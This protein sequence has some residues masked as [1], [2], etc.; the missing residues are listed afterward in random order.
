MGCFS[1]RRLGGPYLLMVDRHADRTINIDEAHRADASF[2]SWA[3]LV[4]RMRQQC[5]LLQDKQPCGS[6]ALHRPDPELVVLK[7]I[8]CRLPAE[9]LI[10]CSLLPCLWAKFG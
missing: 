7:A 9:V 2:S 3:R 5:F 1:P 6:L 10:V 4:G 8:R